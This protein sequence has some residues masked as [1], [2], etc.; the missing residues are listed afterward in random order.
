MF[1]RC[2]K[3]CMFFQRRCG[4]GIDNWKRSALN[5]L[6]AQTISLSYLLVA[7]HRILK[8]KAE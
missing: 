4:L 1:L 6:L 3:E 7:V 8:S 5:C 2:I